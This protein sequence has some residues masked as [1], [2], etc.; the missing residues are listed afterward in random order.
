MSTL[1]V[2]EEQR[3]RA[4][5]PPPRSRQGVVNVAVVAQGDVMVRLHVVV[6]PRQLPVHFEKVDPA[7]GVAT[8]KT[9]DPYGRSVVQ[10]PEVQFRPGPVTVP[11]PTTVTVT[12]YVDGWKVADTVFELFIFTLHGPVPVQTMPHP[13]KMELPLGT[14]TRGTMVPG[15][16]WALQIE[17]PFPQSRAP[18]VTW[19]EP[20]PPSCTVRV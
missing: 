4:R 5:G 3:R 15:A 13:V 8:S 19:P 2:H 17:P 12:R 20:A 7:P 11:L 16:N 14:C 10:V 1:H 18:P 9:P 6:E